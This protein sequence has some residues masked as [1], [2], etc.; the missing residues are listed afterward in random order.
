MGKTTALPK[1]VN[2]DAATNEFVLDPKY[3]SKEII[4]I[5]RADFGTF[6]AP[7]DRKHPPL[8][9]QTPPSYI[10]APDFPGDYPPGSGNP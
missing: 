3:F 10:A 4:K 7:G 9:I 8:A 6:N 1:I 5:I 2:Y